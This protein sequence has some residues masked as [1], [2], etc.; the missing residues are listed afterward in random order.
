MKLHEYIPLYFELHVNVDNRPA[1][2]YKKRHDVARELLPTL[3]DRELEQITPLDVRRLIAGWAARKLSG[4]TMNNYLSLLRNILRCAVA[5]QVAL[6]VCQVETRK[7]LTDPETR[8]LTPPELARVREACRYEQPE[9]QRAVELAVRLGLRVGE[10]RALQYKHIRR[11]DKGRLIVEVKRSTSGRFK[12]IDKTKGRQ[13]TLPL[14][15]D[16]AV[17]VLKDDAVSVEFVLSRPGLTGPLSYKAFDCAIRRIRKRAGVPWLT[18]HSFRHT[19]ATNLRNRGIAMAHIQALLGHVDM[20]TTQRY[21]HVVT[22]ALV[23]A[24]AALDN[25]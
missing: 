7:R 19:F 3:G 9:W 13:R 1:V 20:R 5:D 17:Y 24:M 10:L 16:A 4:K 2:A 6:Q 15:R 12:V 21:A 14:N 8:A 23:D 25:L 11:D 22:D 18:W